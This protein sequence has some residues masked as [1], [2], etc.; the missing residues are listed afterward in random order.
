LHTAHGREKFRAVNTVLRDISARGAR[1]RLLEATSDGPPARA[2][3][4]LLHDLFTS[5]SSWLPLLPSVVQSYRVLAPDLPGFGESEKPP[6]SRFSYTVD[7]MAEAMLDVLAAVRESRAVVCGHGLGAAVALALAADH[8]GVVKNLILVSPLWHGTKPSRVARLARVPVVGPLLFKQGYG[9]AMFR[10]HFRDEV[11]AA[12]GGVDA[13]PFPQARV[14]EWFDRF[15]APSAREAALA[16][17]R[18]LSDPRAVVARLPR[19][20]TPTLL[21][22]GRE[23][24]LVPVSAG[25]RLAREIPHA[26][27]EVLAAGHA[28][29]EEA[30]DEFARVLKGFVD[31]A[32]RPDTRERASRT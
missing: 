1:V 26:R 8:P 14:D 11:Y 13:Q 7:A 16:T 28:P 31:G 20:T 30:P 17:M 21:V 5:R 6:P 24:K 9:R 27:L 18:G 19:V 10:A 2:T 12:P 4:L 22:W 3:L 15:D 32:R 25:R 29:A 23:D